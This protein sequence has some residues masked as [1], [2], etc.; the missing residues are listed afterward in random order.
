LPFEKGEIKGVG[1]PPCETCRPDDPYPENRQ[2]LEI[3]NLCGD[4]WIRAGM[5]GM[6]VALPSSS[7]ESVMNIL[8]ITGKKRRMQIFN[9]VKM[10]SRAIVK[11]K[12]KERDQ[13]K[14]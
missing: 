11:E 4:E 6:I 14:K 13:E 7:V 12:A 10:V 1:P 2:A 3:F 8:E 5:D 9:Q